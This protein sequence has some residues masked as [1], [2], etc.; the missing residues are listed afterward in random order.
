M[1]ERPWLRHYDEGVPAS[2]APYPE[3]TMV[4]LVA[5]AARERPLHPALLFK[6]TRMDFGELDRQS[7]AFAAA[8]VAE[9]VRPGDRV[10]LLLPNCPQFVVA[11]LGIWKARAIAAPLNPTYTERELALPLADSNA[12]II[13]TLTRFYDRVK[14][15]QPDTSVERVIATNIKEHL[16]AHLVVLFT[17]FREKREGHRITL[18]PGDRWFRDVIAHGRTL[19]PPT[20][21]PRPDDDAILLP[22]GGTTGTP[23]CAV[24]T[25]RAF[26]HAG[27]QLRAWTCSVLEPRHDV[28]LLPLPLFHVYGCVGVQALAFVGHNPIALVPNPRDI[29]DLLATIRQVRPAFFCGVPTLFAAILNHPKVRAG[30]VDLSSIK[31]CFSGASAL[32]A[33]TRRQFETMT[34]GH[35]IEGYSL[36]EGMMACLVNPLR[37]T[38]KS[39]SI[40]LPLPDVDVQIVDADDAAIVLGPNQVG[41]LL[42]RAPQLMTRYWNNE[43]ETRTVLRQRPDGGTWLHTGDIGYLDDDGYVFLVDRKKDLIKTS[44]FQVWPREIEE[45]LAAHPGVLEVAAAGMS[46]PL[47]GEVVKAWIVLR[48]GAH[49]SEDELRR[50][51]RERLA[52]YKVP[53]AIEFRS[54]LPKSMVGK[55]LRRALAG[56]QPA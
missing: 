44:G 53:A 33:E 45:V 34:R 28:I 3:T 22:S 1:M 7:T 8:L 51:C 18:R 14:A 48:S 42:V 13:V 54:E 35:L 6:G 19:P 52:P 21:R 41:E 40:G 24:G 47:K 4:E 9:G 16:P 49:A 55:V 39:G 11:E 17:L 27:T 12:R 29:G 38:A 23:K 20:E 32:L 56:R 31:I 10:A 15:I 26:V 43:S 30:R 50:W 36:T 25:H 46:D 37:G 2:L 5:D